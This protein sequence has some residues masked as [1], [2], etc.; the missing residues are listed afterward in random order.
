MSI[1]P[2]CAAEQPEW[3]RI[4]EP[5]DWQMRSVNDISSAVAGALRLKIQSRRLCVRI[6]R[7][8]RVRPPPWISA[9]PSLSNW[10][11]TGVECLQ[12]TLWFD[13]RP[14]EPRNHT[15]VTHHF[16]GWKW[17]KWKCLGVHLTQGGVC[18]RWFLQIRAPRVW[19]TWLQNIYTGSGNKRRTEQLQRRFACVWLSA[20]NSWAR[21]HLTLDYTGKCQ[22]AMGIDLTVFCTGH[23]LAP[24]QH[25]LMWS[26]LRLALQDRSVFFSSGRTPQRQCSVKKQVPPAWFRKNN[27]KQ[28][29]FVSDKSVK[30]EEKGNF[31]HDFFELYNWEFGLFFPFRIKRDTPVYCTVVPV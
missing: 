20:H 10:D 12:H 14:Y 6:A 29:T 23:I 30:F 27:V 1:L 13:A 25:W 19:R 8:Q 11:F 26:G 31:L 22:K 3:L 15:N 4:K 21:T 16:L 7:C 2:E 5:M 17:L 9:C 24:P 28:K 18:R